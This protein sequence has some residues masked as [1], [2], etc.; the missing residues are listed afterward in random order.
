MADLYENTYFYLSQGDALAERDA[1][2][3]TG[4]GSESDTYTILDSKPRSPSF[5]ECY[6]LDG[7]ENPAQIE[8]ANALSSYVWAADRE[9]EMYGDNLRALTHIAVLGQDPVSVADAEGGIEDAAPYLTYKELRALAEYAHELFP[10]S[11]HDWFQT[12][13]FDTVRYFYQPKGEEGEDFTMT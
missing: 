10:G 6:G 3:Y 12:P 7:K 2:I 1:D 11:N 5:V 8:A 9:A 4:K 13:A